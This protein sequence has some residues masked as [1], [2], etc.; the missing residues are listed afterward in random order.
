MYEAR[1]GGGGGRESR[2][3]SCLFAILKCVKGREGN[4]WA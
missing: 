3:K 4:V 1:R 2:V